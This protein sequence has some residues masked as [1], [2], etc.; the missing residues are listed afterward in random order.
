MTEFKELLE[1]DP[2]KI[3][4]PK[5]LDNEVSFQSKSLD[6]KISFFPWYP[7]YSPMTSSKAFVRIGWDKKPLNEGDYPEIRTIMDDFKEKFLEYY[8]PF[9]KNKNDGKEHPVYGTST[10][11]SYT[12]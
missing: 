9:Y 3:N 12:E 4:W 8:L 5:W 7:E 2:E 6:K 1:N 10:N 11:E